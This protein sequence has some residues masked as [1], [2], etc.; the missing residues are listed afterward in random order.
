MTVG[1]LQYPRK[2][3]K[4]LSGNE[5]VAAGPGS[6]AGSVLDF[7]RW[8]ASDLLSNAT[9]G[10]FAEY[11]VA[12][13][14]GISTD[15]VRDEWAPYDLVLP[16]G[17]GVEVKSAAYLQTWG[18]AEL[19][20]IMFK[21]RPSRSWDPETNVLSELPQRS[22]AVYVLALL[23][24]QDKAT[25]DPLEVEQWSFF[26]LPRSFFDKRKRSQSSITLA[27]L[28]NEAPPAVSWFELRHRVCAVLDECGLSAASVGKSGESSG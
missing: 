17:Y 19:S 3:P 14:L 7:W 22:A 26:V 2:D 8:S 1:S 25:V 10:R 6:D 13:A 5:L 16:G 12:K 27:S 4:R 15:G 20:K 21:V 24:H 11:L 9:R 18:H 23:K 28:K